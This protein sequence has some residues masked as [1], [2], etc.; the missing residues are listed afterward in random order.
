MPKNAYKFGSW[1][2]KDEAKGLGFPRVFEKFLT[3]KGHL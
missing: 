1:I 3:H 2:S